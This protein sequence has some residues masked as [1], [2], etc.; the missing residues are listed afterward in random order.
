MGFSRQEYW[1]GL[2]FPSAWDLPNPGNEPGSPTLWADALPSEP[3]GKSHLWV[4][5]PCSCSCSLEVGVVVR[6]NSQESPLF[7]GWPS[8]LYLYDCRGAQCS[9]HETLLL[10]AID[11]A[12]GRPKWTHQA[13][14]SPE[15]LEL[16]SS[17]EEWKRGSNISL[18]CWMK[19]VN[20]KSARGSC[21][22]PWG[23]GKRKQVWIHTHTEVNETDSQRSVGR[24]DE[25]TLLY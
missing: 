23:L 25:K 19:P 10:V 6:I 15:L 20:L 16:E 11:G 21:F 12:S 9:L 2:P 3:L 18:C 17:Q 24:M 7:R 14:S 1:S 22:L 4:K 13:I 8:P 5:N